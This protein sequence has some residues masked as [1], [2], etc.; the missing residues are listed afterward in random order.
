[1]VVFDKNKLYL[2]FLYM[3]KTP[4]IVEGKSFVINCQVDYIQY[5][6]FLGGE[7]GFYNDSLEP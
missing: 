7:H 4:I 3:G 2:I 1:M 5:L 6:K